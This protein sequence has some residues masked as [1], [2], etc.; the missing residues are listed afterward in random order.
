MKKAATHVRGTGSNLK[1]DQVKK[2]FDSKQVEVRHLISDVK[3]SLDEIGSHL[4]DEKVM[5]TQD[6]KLHKAKLADVLGFGDEVRGF[7]QM[8]DD[9]VEQ[10]DIYSEFLGPQEYKKVKDNYERALG[11]MEMLY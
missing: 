5:L 7:D 3:E 1:A 2:R 10:F 6:I 11:T 8:I 9:S 4:R